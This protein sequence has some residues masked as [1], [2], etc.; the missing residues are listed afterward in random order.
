MT[1]RGLPRLG[2]GAITTF[3]GNELRV[4]QCLAENALQCSHKAPLVVIF[5]L[6]KSKGLFIAISKQMKGFDVYICSLKRAFQKR[7][8]VF[9]SVGMDF[10]TRIAFQVVNNL[11]VIISLQIVVR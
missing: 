1:L 5:A 2:T 7:P 6:V 3:G 9:Q 11:A 4:F 8:E 10:A